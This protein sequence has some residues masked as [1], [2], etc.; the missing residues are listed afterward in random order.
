MSQSLSTPSSG[1]VPALPA[2][3]FDPRPAVRQ[4]PPPAPSTWLE[5][6]S[7]TPPTDDDPMLVVMDDPSTDEPPV[8]AGEVG[9]APPPPARPDPIS[10]VTGATPALSARRPGSPRRGK[11][12][13]KPE[14]NPRLV[15]FTPEQ[16]LLILDSWKRSGLPAG[17]FAPLVGLSG[18]KLY[19]W[20]TRFE[21]DGPAGL[22]D[23]VRG[24]QKGSRLPEVTK[25]AI[26]MLKEANP[27]WGV[28]RISAVLERGPS[29]AYASSIT[30]GSS[31]WTAVSR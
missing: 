21:A 13:A 18:H 15:Q 30:A 4:P 24:R 19:A 31:S 9:D 12:L 26:I 10:A 25:R 6:L 1:E 22:M 16:R 27:D 20:K 11:S 29:G 8:G 14:D 3:P 17:D 7:E 23:K 28:E 2:A 5:P